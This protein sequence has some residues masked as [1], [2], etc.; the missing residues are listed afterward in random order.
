MQ[1]EIYFG[2]KMVKLYKIFPDLKGKNDSL[3]KIWY[4]RPQWGEAVQLQSHRSQKDYWGRARA[5]SQLA[6]FPGFGTTTVLLGTT[7]YWARLGWADWVHCK[8]TADYSTGWLSSLSL[9]A[10]V[11]KAIL[12]KSLMPEHELLA[13]LVLLKKYILI[14]EFLGQI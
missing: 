4:F 14:L 2:L 8:S 6:F 5:S 7:G 12:G 10:R 13:Y 11:N 1:K 9:H 3:D